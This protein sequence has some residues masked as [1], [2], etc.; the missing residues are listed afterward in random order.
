MSG[1][2]HTKRRTVT[3][4]RHVSGY[5]GAAL[6]LAGVA[7]LAPHGAF[8]KHER[9]T[10]GLFIGFG[11]ALLFGCAVL[12]LL[13]RKAPRPADVSSDALRDAHVDAAEVPEDTQVLPNLLLLIR[14]R[15]YL[16]RTSETITV[17]DGFFEHHVTKTFQLPE[18]NPFAIES[19]RREAASEGSQDAGQAEEGAEGAPERLVYYLPLKSL[20][21]GALIDNLRVWDARN[22][23]LGTLT[24]SEGRGLV[25]HLLCK[26]AAALT[27]KEQYAE[28]YESALATLVGEVESDAP[29]QG[30]EAAREWADAPN[31]QVTEALEKVK[32]ITRPASWDEKGESWSKHHDLLLELCRAV[33][34]DYIIFVPVLAAPGERIRVNYSYSRPASFPNFSFRQWLRY[35]IGLRPHVHTVV[36]GGI[37]VGEAPH[38]VTF[39]APPGQYVYSC[40]PKA[41]SAPHGYA[42]R[43]G[44]TV[45]VAPYEG[46]GALEYAHVYLRPSRREG[47]PTGHVAL[48]VDFRE[49][50]PGLIGTVAMVALA[51]TVVIWA[52]GLLHTSFFEPKPA[53]QAAVPTLILALPGLLVGWVGAQFTSERIRWTSL[54]TVNGIIFTGLVAIASTGMAVAKSAGASWGP[55]LG[56]AHP[57]WALA[58]IAS[59]LLAGDLIIRLSARSVR[60]AQRVKR[61]DVLTRD[62]L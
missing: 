49:K 59:A 55:H 4:I 5:G 14:S 39:K 43:P 10:A 28:L 36:V 58:M 19:D 1:N 50:P 9:S 21:R 6:A 40:V 44:G 57:L 20:P 29:L 52:I 16:M 25:K 8:G 37:G 2:A 17:G 35:A 47:A 3:W 13:F 38:H 30:T 23:Q 12:D 22:K 18:P 32:G 62:V 24:S 41:L 48:T 53:H 34:D 51:Q 60:F 56:V 33:A 61:N 11:L 54:A 7:M 45:V 31:P 27:G 42:S 26:Y 46:A 15:E